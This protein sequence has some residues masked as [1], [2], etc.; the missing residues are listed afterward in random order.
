MELLY[1]YGRAIYVR[2]CQRLHG[3]VPAQCPHGSYF[4]LGWVLA[5]AA[6]TVHTVRIS[7]QYA[8]GA[9]ARG[10]PIAPPGVLG[11]PR[12]RCFCSCFLFTSLHNPGQTRFGVDRGR[13]ELFHRAQRHRF[14]LF[15]PSLNYS[16]LNLQCF[17]FSGWRFVGRTQ[18]S[19]SFYILIN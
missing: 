14:S 17:P 18:V 13:Q 4:N 12:G 6:S 19:A 2:Y 7:S 9:A 11:R 10:E 15:L 16:F 8:E 5:G 3:S 1:Q